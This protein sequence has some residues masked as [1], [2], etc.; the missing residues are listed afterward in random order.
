MSRNHTPRSCFAARRRET[1]LRLDL[2]RILTA[3]A[4]RCCASLTGNGFGW[5]SSMGANA[6]YLIHEGIQQP[7]ARR[8]IV[9]DDFYIAGVSATPIKY[10]EASFMER[11][12]W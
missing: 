8:K 6:P 10:C 2:S 12:G 11:T 3:R 5:S 1:S 7:G 4:A 9:L